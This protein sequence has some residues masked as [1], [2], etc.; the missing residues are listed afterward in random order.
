MRAHGVVQRVCRG[1]RPSSA[2]KYSCPNLACGIPHVL[3]VG[4]C[5]DWGLALG[6]R[7]ILDHTKHNVLAARINTWGVHY[8]RFRS[9][10]CR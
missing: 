1:S 6:T 9:V 3:H 10:A 4:R 8:R 2:L 5:C 7:G